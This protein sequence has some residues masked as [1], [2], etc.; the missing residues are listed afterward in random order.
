M[1]EYLIL[2]FKIPEDQS[3]NPGTDISDT[4]I[5]IY[6]SKNQQDNGTTGTG[7]GTTGTNTTY[8]NCTKYSF[9]GTEITKVMDGTPVDINIETAPVA[10]PVAAAAIVSS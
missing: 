7:T 2:H 3:V 6:H 10:T 9:D 8:K 4:K 1:S 5:D